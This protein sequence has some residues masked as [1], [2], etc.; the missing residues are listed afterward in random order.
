M[1]IKWNS[2]LWNQ[3][4]RIKFIS[5][6]SEC[7]EVF[8]CNFNKRLISIVNNSDDYKYQVNTFIVAIQIPMCKLY[9]YIEDYL[10]ITKVIQVWILCAVKIQIAWDHKIT[11]F[12]TWNF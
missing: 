7:I 2:F 1:Q 9:I 3:F 4:L 6:Q 5:I 12:P 11:V 10:I 8:Q